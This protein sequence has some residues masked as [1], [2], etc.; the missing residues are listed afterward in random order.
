MA[1]KR[2][3][4]GSVGR[5]SVVSDSELHPLPGIP[6]RIRPTTGNT[7]Y[8]RSGDARLSKSGEGSEHDFDSDEDT[9]V[10]EV[11]IVTDPERAF[12]ASKRKLSR[13]TEKL[14]RGE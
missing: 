12:E 1:T 11:L 8:S 10:I 2:T 4:M 13:E 3:G 6:P 7:S 9:G 14:K 5:D